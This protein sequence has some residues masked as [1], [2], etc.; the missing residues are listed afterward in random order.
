MMAEL[1][2]RLI[3]PFVPRETRYRLRQQQLDEE[4]LRKSVRVLGLPDITVTLL[5][6]AVGTRSWREAELIPQPTFPGVESRW[7]TEGKLAWDGDKL[8]VTGDVGIT[9]GWKT[10]TGGVHPGYR[11]QEVVEAGRRPV[12]SGECPATVVEFAA[13][14]FRGYR[15]RRMFLLDEE[16]RHLTMVPARGFTEEKVAAFANAAGVVFRVYEIDTKGQV[17]PEVLCEEVLFPRSARR[18]RLVHYTHDEDAWKGRW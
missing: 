18:Q 4:A 16:S 13:V 14:G 1:L 17:T 7:N 15:M 10:E 9:G 12:T 11:A 3:T 6:T 5:H 2:R 8:T